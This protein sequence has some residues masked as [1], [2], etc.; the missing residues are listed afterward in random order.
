MFF[1]FYKNIF[2]QE[3]STDQLYTLSTLFL[4]SEKELNSF[5]DFSNLFFIF[6][7]LFGWFCYIFIYLIGIIKYIITCLFLFM[8]TFN[9]SLLFVP[10][11]LLNDF[12]YNFI[13]YLRG[14]AVSSSFIIE[15]FF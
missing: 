2:Q 4:I 9:Y 14:I 5:D 15:L 12:S 1:F 8:P 10:L 7:F 3:N 11:S 13:N 6:L